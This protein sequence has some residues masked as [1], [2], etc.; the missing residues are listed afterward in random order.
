LHLQD[1]RLT[2]RQSDRHR[3]RKELILTRAE[4]KEEKKQYRRLA[5][6]SDF[7]LA[8]QSH[9]TAEMLKRKRPL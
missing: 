6:T 4:Y 9:C 1:R 8:L 2:D 3:Q 7:L 5:G